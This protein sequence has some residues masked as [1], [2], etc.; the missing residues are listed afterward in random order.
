MIHGSGTM[1]RRTTQ[2]LM[3]LVA[4]VALAE[5]PEATLTVTGP[6]ETV[7]AGK[8]VEVVYDVAWEGGPQSLDVLPL[9]IEDVEWG[10]V[11]LVKSE[12]Y[13]DQQLN[14][15]AQTVA[16]TPA[17]PGEYHVPEIKVPL[18][19]PEATFPTEQGTD[20]SGSPHPGAY[21]TLRADPLP[22]IVRA[23]RSSAWISGGLGASLFLA[24]FLWYLAQHRRQPTA[25]GPSLSQEERFSQAR[26][27]MHNARRHR[28]DGDFH[29]YY[30]ELSRA[31]SVFE[32]DSL[33]KKL[34]ELAERAGYANVRPTDDDMDAAWRETERA[35]KTREAD[36]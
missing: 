5:E 27:L 10:E 6:D 18:R 7:R 13:R 35:G 9:E 30:T 12:S 8:T 1:V 26:Q 15:V 22:L 4:G 21:P 20:E 14:H 23:A 17:Q 16:I 11:A 2:I 34:D 25:E 31:A 32:A 29:G 28:L 24:A 19:Y 36:N 33:R 3:A